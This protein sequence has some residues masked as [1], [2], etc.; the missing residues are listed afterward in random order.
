MRHIISIA[1]M[2]SLIW[3]VNSGHYNPLQLSLG[4][5]SVF[6]VVW[7]AHRMDVVDHESQPIHLSKQLPIYYLWLIKKIVISN[8]DVARLVWQPKTSMTPHFQRLLISQKTDMGR[9]IYAN[10]INL[11]PGTLSVDLKDDYVLVHSLT[12]DGMEEL[13]QG[14]MAQRVKELE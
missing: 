12:T 9:V 13:L 1:L 11:T 7:L 10:S 5:I 14:E 4:A 8:I 3:L 2:L 6:F